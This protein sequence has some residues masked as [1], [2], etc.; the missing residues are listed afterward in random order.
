MKVIAKS[1]L[2]AFITKLMLKDQI[3]DIYQ[4]YS[5]AAIFLKA[6]E[7]IPQIKELSR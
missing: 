2:V 3:S 5:C 1:N 4:L 6:S 7:A